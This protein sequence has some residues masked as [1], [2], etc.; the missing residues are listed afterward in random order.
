MSKTQNIIG[1]AYNI[2]EIGINDAEINLYG[3]VVETVPTD[4]WTG[5][6]IDGQFIAVDK[7]LDDLETLKTKDNITVHINSVGGS[8]Y[9]GLAIYNRL[10]E[11]PG[12]VVTVNDGL[13]ASAGSIIFQA[14]NTRKVN[15]A[16]NIMVHPA[17]S[18]LYGYYQTAD[19]KGAIKQ[20][21]AG[22]KAAINVYA[23]R[24]GRSTDEI[25]PIVDRE[26]WFTGQEAVDAGFAD[27]LTEDGVKVNMFMAPDRS[28]IFCNGVSMPAAGLHNIP[29]NIPT[30]SPEQYAGIK[31]IKEL[32]A[33]KPQ[34]NIQTGGPD[35]MGADKTI[36]TA[37]ELRAAYPELV[38]Q[39]EKAAQAQ[40]ETA[41]AASERARIQGIEE[42]AGAIADPEML[43]NAKFGEK[44]LTAQE[45]AFAAMQQ[46][47]RIGANMLNKMQADGE[48]S[49]VNEVKS[50]TNAGTEGGETQNAAELAKNTVAKYN[51]LKGGKK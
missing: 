48:N 32:N 12:N 20:L 9:G 37:E 10:K 26:T 15:S 2:A 42:I 14:G 1:K 51:Q 6:P 38:A 49:G 7:F 33:A 41:G 19:L 34:S 16:S 17:S 22:T 23:E 25:K 28:A 11:L 35:K 4:W 43:N 40:G 18:F 29:A 24:S 50:T 30:M 44:P 46:Q 39:I 13:A 47:A 31:N 3:E 27:E 5:Q 8:L 45:L 21:D 36:N